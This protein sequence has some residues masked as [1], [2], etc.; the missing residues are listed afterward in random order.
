MKRGRRARQAA[1]AGSDVGEAIGRILA[2]NQQARQGWDGD[3]TS[4]LVLSAPALSA[5]HLVHRALVQSRSRPQATGQSTRNQ[6]A[7]KVESH[8]SEGPGPRPVEF[9]L[10]VDRVPLSPP[11]LAAT[12][13][14]THVDRLHT[15][16]VHTGDRA[17][18]WSTLR[19]FPPTQSPP[20]LTPILLSFYL[21]ATYRYG[22]LQ[23]SA[24]Q[25]GNGE[26]YSIL[27]SG[28]D[29][30]ATMPDGTVAAFNPGDRKSVV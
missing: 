5:P 2:S 27:L 14:R 19:A 1:I 20:W 12:S 4:I 17:L 15:T 18:G 10:G 6:Q 8:Q 22:L 25:A 23:A 13:V 3:G 11:T 26:P 7:P 9:S 30:I 16:R 21:P 24:E 29:M 28:T